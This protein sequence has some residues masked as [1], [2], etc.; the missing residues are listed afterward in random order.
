M[1]FAA[2]ARS[3]LTECR[4]LRALLND[5][6]V[7]YGDEAA[8]RVRREEEIHPLP[9]FQPRAL[10]LSIDL[11]VVSEDGREALIGLAVGYHTSMDMIQL[12]RLDKA[13]RWFMSDRRYFIGPIT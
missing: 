8:G 6:G 5:S 13:G 10:P 3:A 9:A 4:E 1:F 2:S 12:M 11:P 7:L